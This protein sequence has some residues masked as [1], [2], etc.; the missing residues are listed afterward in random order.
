MRCMLTAH[1]QRAC[2]RLCS[3]FGVLQLRRGSSTEFFCGNVWQ[4]ILWDW[5]NDRGRPLFVAAGLLLVHMT[6]G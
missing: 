2:G 1:K 3:V 6:V 5:L 4:V